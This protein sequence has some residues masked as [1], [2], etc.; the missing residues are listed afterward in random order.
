MIEFKDFVADELSSA[1]FFKQATHESLR[2]V[3]GE[4]NGWIKASEVD[5]INV[6]TVVLPNIHSPH[7]EGS[8]DTS[9]HTKGDWTSTWHQ[10]VRVWFRGQ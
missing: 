4:V 6:E 2:T 8:E 5:V 7:E 9:L 3:L 10:V 1:G